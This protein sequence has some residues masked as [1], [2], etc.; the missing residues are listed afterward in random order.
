MQ[1]VEVCG[2]ERRSIITGWNTY[3]N[4]RTTSTLNDWAGHGG[5][6]RLSQHFF[7]RRGFAW[8]LSVFTIDH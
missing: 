8:E 4:Y 2:E 1:A 6:Y 5:A 7:E 3:R